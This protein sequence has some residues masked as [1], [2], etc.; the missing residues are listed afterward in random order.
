MI[1]HIFRLAVIFACFAPLSSMSQSSLTVS[2]LPA[3]N[4]IKYE[5]NNI[6]SQGDFDIGFGLTFRSKLSDNLQLLSVERR[7]GA[8]T[9]DLFFKVLRAGVC[10]IQINKS[11]VSP[12]IQEIKA[13]FSSNIVYWALSSPSNP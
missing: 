9:Y 13:T 2:A 3:H 12:A 6:K 4:R 1:K 5:K 10:T 7:S 8:S 11:G